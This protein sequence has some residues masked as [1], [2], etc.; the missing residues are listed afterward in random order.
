M[1]TARA[2]SGY[3]VHVMPSGHPLAS[4]TGKHALVASSVVMQA[5]RPPLRVR[6]QSAS[7]SHG[8]PHKQALQYG[9]PEALHALELELAPT[10]QQVK[11]HRSS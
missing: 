11:P 9:S 3:G 4:Q 1:Q 8:T 6:G 2:V 7:I 5:A 10:F